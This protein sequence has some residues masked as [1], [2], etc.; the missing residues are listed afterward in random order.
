MRTGDHVGPDAPSDRSVALIVKR[1][2]ERIGLDPRILAGHS[3]RSGGI[4]AAARE[5][6]SER[7]IVRLSRHDCGGP[8]WRQR[9]TQGTS[10][11]S[12]SGRHRVCRRVALDLLR[13]TPHPR[14]HSLGALEGATQGGVGVVPDR[15]GDLENARVTVA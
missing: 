2:A 1:P 4:T 5:G 14:R 13:S 12:R 7:E 8:A 15:E 10:Q 11:A 3:L 9:V 6:H